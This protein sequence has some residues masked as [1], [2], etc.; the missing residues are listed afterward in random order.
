M[1]RERAAGELGRN[2]ARA[3]STP[4]G[5]L[6]GSLKNVRIDVQRGWHLLIIAQQ[7]SSVNDTSHFWPSSLSNSGRNPAT[8]P[9]PAKVVGP[10]DLPNEYLELF[11]WAICQLHELVPLKGG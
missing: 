9:Q 11:T 3:S 1:S 4:R 5:Q 8:T 2:P 10:V 7:S 6:L